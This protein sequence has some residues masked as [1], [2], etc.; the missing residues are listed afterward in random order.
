MNFPPI[1]EKSGGGRVEDTLNRCGH[2]IALDI[3]REQL[4]SPRCSLTRAAP[5][6]GH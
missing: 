4:W 2:R 3:W 1:L 6:A 5:P